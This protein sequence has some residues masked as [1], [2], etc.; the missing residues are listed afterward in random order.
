MQKHIGFDRCLRV[1]VIRAAEME[2]LLSRANALYE[3][4]PLN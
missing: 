4:E 1:G 3:I 2:N